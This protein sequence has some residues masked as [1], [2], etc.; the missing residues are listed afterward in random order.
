MASVVKPAATIE[1][2]GSNNAA[3]GTS[4]MLPIADESEVSADA[5]MWRKLWVGWKRVGKKI[6]NFQ[7]RVLLGI[8]YA[9][10]LAP[11]AMM[12]RWRSDPLA[13]KPESKRG[14]L[15]RKDREGSPSDLARRQF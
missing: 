10:F 15:A 14:W 7:A 4:A 9:I 6:G 8:F 1:V 13:I 5:P 11:F 12:L 3:V 2:S